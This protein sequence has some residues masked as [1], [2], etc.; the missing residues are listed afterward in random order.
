MSAGFIS[1]SK[2]RH[3]SW[4]NAH[5]T[6]L[7]HKKNVK[8]TK[9]NNFVVTKCT[10]FKLL[11]NCPTFPNGVQCGYLVAFL[12]ETSGQPVLRTECLGRGAQRPHGFGQS[13]HVKSQNFLKHNL[14][15][16][17]LF[18]PHKGNWQILAIIQL[19]GYVTAEDGLQWLQSDSLPPPP[20]T[21]HRMWSWSWRV[22]LQW[23]QSDPPTDFRLSNL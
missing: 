17:A 15:N 8:K 22:K 5:C 2:K 16:T 4:Q 7:K 13:V 12:N 9:Y 6:K 23:L 18:T 3:F 21:T 14:L 11:N 10:L 20:T 1:T 19:S